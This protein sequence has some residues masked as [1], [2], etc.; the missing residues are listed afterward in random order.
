[1][2]IWKFNLIEFRRETKLFLL[3][4]VYHTLY[5]VSPSLKTDFQNAVLQYKQE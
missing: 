2:I 1:M 4:I 5:D 3:E